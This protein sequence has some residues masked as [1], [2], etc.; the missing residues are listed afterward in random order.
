MTVV[1]AKLLLLLGGLL[2]IGA[3]LLFLP[4]GL[5]EIPSCAALLARSAGDVSI[6]LPPNCMRKGELPMDEMAKYLDNDRKRRG[7]DFKEWIICSEVGPTTYAGFAFLHDRHW[8]PSYVPGTYQYRRTVIIVPYAPPAPKGSPVVTEI[9]LM[10]WRRYFFQ[11]TG[12]CNG[13]YSVWK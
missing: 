4:P 3:A 6:P 8:L 9:G 13:K 7:L 10:P 11:I 1:R 2:L 5:R 12:D